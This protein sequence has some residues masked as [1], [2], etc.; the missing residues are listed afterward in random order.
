MI[1]L[2]FLLRRVREGHRQEVVGRERHLHD[3]R[4]SHNHLRD[5]RKVPKDLQHGMLGDH[6]EVGISVEIKEIGNIIEKQKR[7]ELMYQ[8]RRKGVQAKQVRHQF[9]RD[10]NL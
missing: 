5:H 6:Q 4:V 10:L 7:Q 3:L 2:I 8:L 1:Q 9:Q